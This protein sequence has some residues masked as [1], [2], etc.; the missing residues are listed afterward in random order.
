MASR[1]KLDEFKSLSSKIRKSNITSSITASILVDTLQLDKTKNTQK[2]DGFSLFFYMEI[3]SSGFNW[4]YEK[5]VLGIQRCLL[6]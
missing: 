6:L 3:D 1:E 5:V 2:L 4:N